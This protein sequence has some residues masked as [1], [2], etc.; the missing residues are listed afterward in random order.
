MLSQSNHVFF[1]LISHLNTDVETENEIS[2]NGISQAELLVKKLQE[3]L[4]QKLELID[5]YE[6]EIQTLRA[7]KE[8]VL[9]TLKLVIPK[10]NC[11]IQHIHKA[12]TV[13]YQYLGYVNPVQ[14][15]MTD[16]ELIELRGGQ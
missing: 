2:V 6:K 8:E 1:S 16:E 4:T 13:L 10:D 3:E 5:R 14:N 11:P 12:Q 9:Q 7:E 15:Y